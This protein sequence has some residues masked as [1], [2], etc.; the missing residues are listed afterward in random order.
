MCDSYTNRGRNRSMRRM[1]TAGDLASGPYSS[2][3]TTN[4]TGRDRSRSIARSFHVARWSLETGTSVPV[5]A[6]WTRATP[7]SEKCR[8]D[9]ALEIFVDTIYFVAPEGLT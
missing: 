3:H 6:V 8:V 7:G 5:A 4:S 9:T 2:V 1:I